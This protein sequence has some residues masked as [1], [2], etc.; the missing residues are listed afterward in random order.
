MKPGTPLPWETFYSNYDTGH[1][2]IF[3]VDDKRMIVTID[4]PVADTIQPEDAAYI[5]HAANLY[6]ELVEALRMVLTTTKPDKLKIAALLAK[7]DA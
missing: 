3:A 6:P 1:L 5:A 2:C 7:C 4:D